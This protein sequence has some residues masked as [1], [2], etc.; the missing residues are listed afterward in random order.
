MLTVSTVA[1]AKEIIGSRYSQQLLI[2]TRDSLGTANAW[3]QC[4]HKEDVGH[5]TLSYLTSVALGVFICKR[6]VDM[7]CVYVCVG[8]VAV[9]KKRWCMCVVIDIHTPIVYTIYKRQLCKSARP[10]YKAVSWTKITRAIN[11]FM[12]LVLEFYFWKHSLKRWFKAQIEKSSFN[13]RRK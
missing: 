10:F 9:K 3:N 2:E 11:M 1:Q 5:L 4:C 8:G 12:S 13:Y 7:V 6:E